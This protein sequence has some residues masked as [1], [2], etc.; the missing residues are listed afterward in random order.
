MRVV[1]GRGS[2]FEAA[3]VAD[4]GHDGADGN[5]SDD[6]PIPAQK[7]RRRQT[8][9]HPTHQAP[10]ASIAMSADNEASTWPDPPKHYLEKRRRPP[11]PPD[12]EFEMFGIKRRQ[13]ETGI[14]EAPPLEEQVHTASTEAE[15]LAELQRLNTATLAKFRELLRTMQE[16]PTQC[17]AKGER[18][19]RRCLVRQSSSLFI[20]F[21]L[22]LSRAPSRCSFALALTTTTALCHRSCGDPHA[23][24]Q[25]SVPAQHAPSVP[26]ARGAHWPGGGS[27]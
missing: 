26:S 23:L 10:R 21:A 5:V 12:G 20:Y 22:S 7:R 2:A 15:A 24:P 17:G 9:D 14:P 8:S 6:S 4:G 1:G 11:P 3:T 19:E 18:R 27:D 13:V 16:T 25:P